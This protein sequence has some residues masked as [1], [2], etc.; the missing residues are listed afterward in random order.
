MAHVKLPQEWTTDGDVA[1]MH[2]VRRSGEKVKVLASPED[3]EMLERYRWVLCGRGAV[4]TTWLSYC[5][6]Q[7]SMHSIIM[8]RNHIDHVNRNPRDNRRENLRP[9]TQQ[10]NMQNVGLRRQNK[11]NGVKF[12]GVFWRRDNTKKRYRARIRLGEG[13]TRD[14]GSFATPEEAA[15]AYDMAAEIC[16]GEFA[17]TNRSL[18]LR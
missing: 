2:I 5:H 15:D 7:T 16:H 10:Q 11:L 1:Y 14:L 3:V 12:K 9:A 4:W 13:D 18:G 8:G 17:C 6:E